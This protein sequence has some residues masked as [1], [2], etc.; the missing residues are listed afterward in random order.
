MAAAPSLRIDTVINDAYGIS[1]PRRLEHLGELTV[2]AHDVNRRLM[3]TM[4][5][6]QFRNLEARSRRLSSA[7]YRRS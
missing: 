1:V 2:K 6:G 3:P 5:A 4:R 7:F